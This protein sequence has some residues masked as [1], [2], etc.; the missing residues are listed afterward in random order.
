MVEA[1]DKKIDQDKE[2]IITFLGSF[3]PFHLN[4]KRSMLIARDFIISKG[5]NFHK[6]LVVL[7][8]Q[9]VLNWKHKGTEPLS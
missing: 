4:H 7:T 6:F 2:L 1:S 8:P 5:L 3:C 9:E